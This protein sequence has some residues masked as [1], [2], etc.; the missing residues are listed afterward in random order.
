MVNAGPNETVVEGV[1]RGLRDNGYIDG[2]SIRIEYRGAQG[3]VDRLPA[4]A[5][6][7]VRLKV[8]AIVVGTEASARAARHET[9][10]IPIV[11]V[12]YDVDPL[13]VGLIDSFNRP[14][15]NMT[16]IFARQPELVGKRLELLREVLPKLKHVAVLWDSFSGRQ[17][18]QTRLAARALGVELTLVEVRP[19]Y[20][21]EQAFRTVKE[22]KAG[23]LLVLFSPVF[24]TE[25]A[26]I[27]GLAIRN[28][29][30]T[31]FQDPDYIQA[32][33]LMAYGPSIEDAFS[34]TAYYIDRLIKGAN[35]RDLPVEQSA[36]FKLVVNLKTAKALGIT[37]PESILL[38]ADEV[39]R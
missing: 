11:F 27:S 25:E 15:G 12:M 38:R 37:I 19:P 22:S 32:G 14:G 3:Q 39:I 20:D 35:P 6:E 9:K 29:L 4:L 34:R 13:A 24:T 31:M 16:G 2:E 1:R 18:E 26:K 8:D 23:A 33:G 17:L 10:T 36:T 21:F 7:L 5:Q 28:R 30:P